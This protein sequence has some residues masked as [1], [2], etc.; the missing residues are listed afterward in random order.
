MN[1]SEHEPPRIVDESDEDTIE[2]E[3][4]PEEVLALSRAAEATVAPAR[5]ESANE[6]QV[7][8]PPAPAGAPARAQSS[9]RAMLLLAL[10][11]VLVVGVAG[12]FWAFEYSAA[13]PPPVPVIA[14]A[15][16]VIPPPPPPPA[17]PPAPPVTYRNPFDRSEV[18]E[19]PAGTSTAEARQA[20]A[21]MLLQRALERA[22]P[23]AHV[24][25]PASHAANAPTPTENSST[26]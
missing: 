26:P 24:K 7:G 18:F 10:G 6:S 15:P 23:R 3:L 12:A 19:F 25:H 17:D 13:P 1:A 21:D 9:R 14:R 4:L 20:V 16:V 8:P 2:L 22:P 5:S 11:A